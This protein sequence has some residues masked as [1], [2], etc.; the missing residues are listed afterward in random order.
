[1]EL[2]KKIKKKW[3]DALRSGKFKPATYILLRDDCHCCLGVLAEIH[4]QME[5]IKNGTKLRCNGKLEKNDLD[6]QYTPLHE[7]LGGFE[8]VQELWEMNDSVADAEDYGHVIPL[9]E[10]LKT[11][12]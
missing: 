3:L 4:P 2:T 8:S 12:D 9:I 11:V 6:K 1:M 7:M 5:I 10:K